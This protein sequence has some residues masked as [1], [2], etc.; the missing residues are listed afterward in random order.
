MEFQILVDWKQDKVIKIRST[1]VASCSCNIRTFKKKWDKLKNLVVD[2]NAI[3]QFEIMNYIKR[4]LK[5]NESIIK[6]GKMCMNL[7][8]IYTVDFARSNWR[9]ELWNDMW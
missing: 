3:I 6:S 4:L 8:A 2:C 7:N 1:F 5:K 9:L